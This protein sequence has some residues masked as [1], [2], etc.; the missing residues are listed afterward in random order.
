MKRRVF[1]AVGA[2][3]LAGLP[4]AYAQRVP[5]IGFLTL[6]RLE[7][8]SRIPGFVAELRALGWVEGKTLS[9]LWRPAGGDV[10]RLAADAEELV[11]E[12]V[13]VIV[14]IQPQAVDAARRATATIPIV[15][16]VAQDPVGMGYAKTLSRPGGNITGHSSMVADI[17]AKELEL[18]RRALPRC[19]RVAVVLNPTNSRAL[20]PVR[21]SVEAAARDF[22]VKLQFLEA[23]R[24]ADIDRAFSAAAAD[25]AEAVFVTPDAFFFQHRQAIARIALTHRLPT[26]F[27][28]REH[29]EAGGMLS[30]GPDTGEQYRQVAHYVDRILR[31]AKPA[32]LPIEQPSKFELLINMKTAKALGVAI[33]PSLRVLA[34]RVIE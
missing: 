34:D 19:A 16:G 5:R 20:G 27:V 2:A 29:V 4:R 7:S 17:G 26:I 32:E 13:E 21:R 8:D 11:R 9:I 24:E 33:A 30:Y 23:S 28:Q 10:R 15:F 14:G 25:R 6:L 12:K 3:C 18:L 22:G 31:G 1:L